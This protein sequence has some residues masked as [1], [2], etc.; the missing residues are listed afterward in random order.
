M[1]KKYFITFILT[2]L[3]VVLTGCAEEEE[4][5]TTSFYGGTEGVSVEFKKYHLQISLIK[6]KKFQ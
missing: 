3:A 2:L 6:G 4:E 5:K 1:M